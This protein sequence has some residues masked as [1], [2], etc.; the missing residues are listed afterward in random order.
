M[1]LDSIVR[2]KITIML[3]IKICFLKILFVTYLKH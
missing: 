1:L 3:K 2:V